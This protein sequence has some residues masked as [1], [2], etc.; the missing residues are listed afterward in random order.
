M[1]IAKEEVGTTRMDGRV[2]ATMMVS[3]IH[4]TWTT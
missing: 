2:L 1:T 4:L 3:P